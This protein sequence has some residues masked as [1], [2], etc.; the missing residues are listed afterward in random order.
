MV[1]LDK[2]LSPILLLNFQ[3]TSIVTIMSQ[4]PIIMLRK[5]AR[6]RD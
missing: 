3:L 1:Q 2:Y 4:K 5:I 6:H